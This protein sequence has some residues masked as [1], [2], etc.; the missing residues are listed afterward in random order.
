[1][2][3]FLG[4]V[5]SLFWQDS[6]KLDTTNT[7]SLMFVNQNKEKLQV[8]RITYRHQQGFFCDFEDKINKNNKLRL[9]IGLG[10]Q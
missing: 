5:A 2:F 10:E 1:M 8:E 6:L 3:K 9:N 7:Q 4:I